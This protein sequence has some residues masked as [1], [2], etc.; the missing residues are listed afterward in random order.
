MLFD[1]DYTTLG[2]SLLVPLAYVALSGYVS[3]LAA[4]FYLHHHGTHRFI[5]LN[6][7]LKEF[8]RIWLWLTTSVVVASWVTIHRKSH[9]ETSAAISPPAEPVDNIRDLAVQS[10]LYY[11]AKDMTT[12]FAR[13]GKNRPDDWIENRVFARLPFL[14]LLVLGVIDVLLFGIVGLLVWAVQ[15]LANPILA[16]AAAGPVIAGAPPPT[17]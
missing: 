7:P 12:A 15:T 1:L 13:F 16:S 8:L 17:S 9:Y 6:P 5:V 3:F 10:T 14:G 2:P 11:R 4:K